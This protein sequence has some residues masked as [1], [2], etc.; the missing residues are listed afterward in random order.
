MKSHNRIDFLVTKNDQPVKAGGEKV[1]LDVV[2][3]AKNQQKLN[4]LAD[5]IVIYDP[6]T[7]LTLG[8]GDI[9]TANQVA[10]A[11]GYDTNNDGMADKL[12][13][14]GD[15]L[16]LTKGLID[17]TVVPASCDV[18]Q[19]VDVFFNCTQAES[20]YS[21]LVRLD[22][23]YTRSRYPGANQRP[24]YV[25]TES[26]ELPACDSCDTPHDCQALAQGIVD[27]INNDVDRDKNMLPYF[28]NQD[29]VERYQPFSASRLLPNGYDFCL[30][31]DPAGCDGVCGQFDAIEGINIDGTVTDFDFT[32]LPG[33]ATKS[34]DGQLS[35]IIGSI[36]EALGD[37]GFA[38]VVAPTGNCCDKRI[39]IMTDDTISSVAL[40]SD[41][42]DVASCDTFSPFAGRSETCGIRLVAH[43]IT[44][45]ELN[46]FPGLPPNEATPNTF[47][48]RIDVQPL[49]DGF[50]ADGFDVVE[51]QSPVN[52]EG[53]GLI[54]S[55]REYKQQ[56]GGGD[57]RSNFRQ[58]NRRAGHIGLPDRYSNAR[59]GR[60]D[61]T[62]NY[63]AWSLEYM[64]GGLSFAAGMSSPLMAK[65]LAH[66]LVPESDTTTHGSLTPYI[67]AI[68]S[69]AGLSDATAK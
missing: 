56:Y 40:R 28:K 22:D 67:T 64:G 35:R 9:A 3:G 6:T 46:A 39:Q 60:V 30:A 37:A 10:V 27:K 2:D 31:Y 14:I 5:Q 23:Y 24:R 48:R 53:L 42:A 41:G 29:L 33:D 12:Q 45:E 43:A 15:T 19:I 11:V 4:V 38:H 18:P 17:S 26:T 65:H 25:Y 59:A 61:K 58:S 49:G 63:R 44:L 20:A 7:N 34:V 47:I 32:T 66:I 54:W 52:P 57:Y 68:R 62:T 36:N 51:V 13:H 55:K 16:D 1:L 69:A 8:S 50:A 21:L